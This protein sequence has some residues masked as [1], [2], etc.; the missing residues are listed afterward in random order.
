MEILMEIQRI[1]MIVAT[2]KQLIF[3]DSMPDQTE[4]YLISRN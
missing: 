3:Q 4:K 2:S 1:S